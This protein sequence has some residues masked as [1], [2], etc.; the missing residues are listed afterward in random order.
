MLLRIKYPNW[1]TFLIKIQTTKVQKKVSFFY[2]NKP[3]IYY[4]FMF[5]TNIKIFITFKRKYCFV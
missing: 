2:K 3:R 5:Y 4:F 1:D